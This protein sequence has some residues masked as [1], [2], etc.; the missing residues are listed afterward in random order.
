MTN[1]FV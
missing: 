1:G